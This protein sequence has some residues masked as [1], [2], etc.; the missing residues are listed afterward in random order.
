MSGHDSLVQM[1]TGGSLGLMVYLMFGFCIITPTLPLSMKEALAML[2]HFE[3]GRAD[4][5]R[6]RRYK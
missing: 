1:L 6:S 2:T 3:F 4:F 5:L